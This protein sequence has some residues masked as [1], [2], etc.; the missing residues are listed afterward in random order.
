MS[1]SLRT[2][3]ILMSYARKDLFRSFFPKMKYSGVNF[4]AKKSSCISDTLQRIQK[5]ILVLDRDV[6]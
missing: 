4:F 3:S 6:L 2:I 1:I 5:I